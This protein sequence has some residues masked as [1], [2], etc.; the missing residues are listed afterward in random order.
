MKP[1][2]PLWRGVGETSFAG[3]RGSLE[4]RAPVPAPA[5]R[6]RVKVDAASGISGE[7]VQSELRS[8][9]PFLL[10]VWGGDRREGGV[11]RRGRVTLKQRDRV[12]WRRL[13]LLVSSV[14]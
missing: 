1:E 2:F 7:L 9:P 13:L 11:E 3:A 12:P 10:T 6:T 8:K 5:L 14:G 4:R